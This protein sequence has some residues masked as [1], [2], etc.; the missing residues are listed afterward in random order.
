[1]SRI[2]NSTGQYNH[3]FVSVF[4]LVTFPVREESVM[5]R[6]AI[7]ITIKNVSLS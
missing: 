4:Y 3:F 2:T 6:L 5:S 7:S 1:M